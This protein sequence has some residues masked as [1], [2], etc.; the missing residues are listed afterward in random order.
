MTIIRKTKTWIL[1]RK[2][3]AVR[4]DLEKGQP[5]TKAKQ[6][7]EEYLKYQKWIRS[8][9]FK[10]N[11][12]RV[13]EERDGHKCMTC[14]RTRSEGAQLCC[15][16]RAYT[17]LY[18]GDQSEVDDCITLCRTCHKMVHS[19]RGNYQRFSMKNPRNQAGNNVNK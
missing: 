14:G 19:A 10:E 17:H 4:S 6:R 16:H 8:K 11:V 3:N 1:G 7:N 2:P 12:K 5:Q 15:H 9:A 13:V 18:C